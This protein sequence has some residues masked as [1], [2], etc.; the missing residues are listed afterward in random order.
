MA[1]PINV[2]AFLRYTFARE[3]MLAS[4]STQSNLKGLPQSTVVMAMYIVTVLKGQTW[5]SQKS[6]LFI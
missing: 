5:N 6:E 1:A 4:K 2:L 3:Q